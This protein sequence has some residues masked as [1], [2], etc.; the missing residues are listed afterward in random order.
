MNH[1]TPPIPRYRLL[2]ATWTAFR[3]EAALDDLPQTAHGAAALSKT[4]R[5]LDALADEAIHLNNRD[6]VSCITAVE[7][8]LALPGDDLI[9]YFASH[10]L[11]SSGPNPFFRLATGDTR[12]HGD[13]TRA[14]PLQE[15]TERLAR[16]KAKRKL[17][18][19]D[20]CYSGRAGTSL[21]NQVFVGSDIPPGLCL[22]ASS[23]PFE[24][25]IAPADQALSS[26]TANLV[27]T[28]STGVPGESLAL[29]TQEL[30]EVLERQSSSRKLPRPWLVAQG[31]AA[32]S[33]TFS[34][35][36][37]A[38]VSLDPQS[39]TTQT[40]RYDH[41]AEILYVDDEAA[42]R[43]SFKKEIEK[44][45]HHVTVAANPP[46]AASELRAAHFDII[47][48]DLLQ[49]GDA[50]AKDLIQLCSAEAPDSD[51]FVVSRQG[52]GTQ[53]IW[54]QL[55]AVFPYP[56]RI[57]AFL[58]KPSYISAITLLAD[59]IRETRQHILAH[60]P[61]VEE[62][63][64]L[65]AGR[66]IKRNPDLIAQ[67]ESLQL[68]AR[69]TIEH[70]V[71]KWFAPDDNDSAFVESMTLRL[72]DSGRSMCSVF[73]LVPCL[74]GIKTSD[75]MPL[76]L[77]I[78]PIEEIRQEEARYDEYVQVGVPLDLRTDK[79]GCAGVGRIG[80]LLYSFRGGRDGTIE[81]VGRLRPE[82]IAESLDVVFNPTTGRRWLAA[83][84]ASVLP[85]NHYGDLGY[86]D[87]RRAT[88]ILNETL[89]SL[90]PTTSK[91]RTKKPSDDTPPQL[92]N[93]YEWAVMNNSHE[94]ALVH[95][96]LNLGNLVRCGDKR[97]ALIDYRTV[98]IGPRL[99][100]FATIEVGCWLTALSPERARSELFADARTS[101]SDEFWD[102]RDETEIPEWLRSSRRLAQQ[103][104]SLA[105]ANFE[106]ASI[107][108]YASLLWL[109]AVRRSE[110]K[111]GATSAVERRTLKVLSPALAL[112]AQGMIAREEAVA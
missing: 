25:S 112:A 94:S 7:D 49:D 32:R 14:L 105:F 98:G 70:L 23:G 51:I 1:P 30:F 62:A 87:F 82:E 5:S 6:G 102:Q 76:V 45:G 50:P 34:N 68:Q 43:R 91:K 67:S 55:D 48:L 104:R 109:A 83:Q 72:I 69:I 24:T 86:E 21:F 37:A 84:G 41:R 56:N 44:A 99:V 89:T 92:G 18:I 57:K 71:S 88:E 17:L 28:L 85:R 11:V 9:L 103:C 36:A 3:P 65:I 79:I 61:N 26:F 107:V 2:C 19:V 75:V 53:E 58:W 38:A 35:A 16:S 73:T 29:S 74:R 77:K 101:V 63:V 100:D 15:I 54:S 93:V 46:A 80:G 12:E 40:A 20:A 4:L 22:L 8:F 13:L 33:I 60:V 10:G 31:S 59:R 106:D 47:V 42:Y 64:P 97:Y 39:Y 90:L 96:D 111:S 52:K 110:F 108:E 95:G 78:G 66:M 27:A 81:E